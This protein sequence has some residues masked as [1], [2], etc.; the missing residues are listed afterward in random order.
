MAR[1]SRPT[2]CVLPQVRLLPRV[3]VMNRL[4]HVPRCTTHRS[5]DPAYDYATLMKT[6]LAVAVMWNCHVQMHT[7]SAL[8]IL[9]MNC[10]TRP[11]SSACVLYTG[12][13]CVAIDTFLVLFCV[14]FGT[15]LA[16]P[17]GLVAGVSPPPLPSSSTLLNSF[18]G[19]GSRPS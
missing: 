16:M 9:M 19:P 17:L 14:V 12:N 10:N 3:M 5:L 1:L 15:S 6:Y 13:L 7:I 8:S 2:P 11:F 4:Q 18:S